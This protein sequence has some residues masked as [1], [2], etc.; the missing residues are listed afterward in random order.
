MLLNDMVIY[1][2]ILSQCYLHF[3]KYHFYRIKTEDL[4]FDVYYNYA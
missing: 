1:Y 2:L 3:F 4:A